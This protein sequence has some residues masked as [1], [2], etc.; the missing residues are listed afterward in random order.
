MVGEMKAN[1]TKVTIF[2]GMVGERQFRASRCDRCRD[3]KRVLFI[4][5]DQQS[6][7]LAAGRCPDQE[8][9]GMDPRARLINI[10]DS[11]MA[12]DVSEKLG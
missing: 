11:F 2:N 6:Y 1:I 7:V 5:L 10:A 4:A 9:I 12:C 8:P 3:G